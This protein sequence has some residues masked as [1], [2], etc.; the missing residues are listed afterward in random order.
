M[1]WEGMACGRLVEWLGLNPELT[2]RVNARMGSARLPQPAR[3]ACVAT[4]S[5]LCTRQ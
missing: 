3:I 1:V 4:F 5:M 2:W